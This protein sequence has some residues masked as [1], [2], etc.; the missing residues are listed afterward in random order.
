MEI[1]TLEQVKK[2]LNIEQD[3]QDDDSLIQGYI[4]AA[5]SMVEAEICRDL[6]DLSD[7]EIPIARQA[8]LLTVGDYYMQREDTVVGATPSS[9]PMG[10]KRLCFNIRRF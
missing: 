9:V 8:V 3:Y 4:T 5:I 6:A 7:K 2:H 1:V 10:V